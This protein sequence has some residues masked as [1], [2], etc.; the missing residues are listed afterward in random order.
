MYISI[1]ISKNK[2]NKKGDGLLNLGFFKEV[3]N[4]LKNIITQEL[5]NELSKFLNKNSTLR[6]EDC[7]Y[8][9]VSGNPN[10][11]YLQNTNTDKVFEEKNLPQEIKNVVS[12]GYILRYKNGQYKI[13]EELTDE[14]FESQI[15][16]AEYKKIQEQFINESNISKIDSNTKFTMVSR[17][18]NYTILEYEKNKNIKVPNVLLP[19]FM[20]ANKV[21]HYEDGKFKII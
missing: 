1:Q 6:E 15:D 9:V 17:N 20:N 11:V 13:E 2:L 7:L 16:I 12:E 10:Q 4:S 21:L 14:Y 3:E 18:K 19:Y 8:F 5:I